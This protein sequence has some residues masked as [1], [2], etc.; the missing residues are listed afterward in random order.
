MSGMG[1]NAG[2][3]AANSEVRD[4]VRSSAEVK[5]APPSPRP[6]LLGCLGWITILLFAMYLV[7]ERLAWIF[8]TFLL[9]L[10]I[11]ICILL[12]WD[13]IRAFGEYPETRP[14]GVVAVLL[15]APVAILGAISLLFGVAIILWVL[16]N[17]LVE[18]QPEFQGPALLAGFGLGPG[19][20]AFG[21]HLIRSPY[22]R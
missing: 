3:E 19:L 11:P 10:G 2:E 9:L 8:A 12:Y 6:F 16:Y 1:E 5:T 4:R 20:I 22:S 18:R 15:A 13:F 7:P 21:W 17:L 14:K